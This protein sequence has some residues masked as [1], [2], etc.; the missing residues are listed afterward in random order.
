[1]SNPYY[2]PGPV[3]QLPN[4]Y[5][6]WELEEYRNPLVAEVAQ[7]GSFEEYCRGHFGWAAP[8]L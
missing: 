5:A 7:V 3:I 8:C 4:P 2:T 6:P 1:M